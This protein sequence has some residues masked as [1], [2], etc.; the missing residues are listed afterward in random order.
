MGM[1]VASEWIQDAKKRVAVVEIVQWCMC[2]LAETFDRK[3]DA[4]APCLPLGST[5][6]I[7]LETY[8]SKIL[9]KAPSVKLNSK[10]PLQI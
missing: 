7:G 9:S 3:G 8:T 6:D 5:H 1:H 10:S 4:A 2:P